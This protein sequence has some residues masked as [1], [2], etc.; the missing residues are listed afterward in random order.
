MPVSIL[1]PVSARR[2][3]HQPEGLRLKLDK[4]W[5]RVQQGKWY[6]LL[7]ELHIYSN[8][9]LRHFYALKFNKEAIMHKI[10]QMFCDEWISCKIVLNF[11][12]ILKWKNKSSERGANTSK[13][14][15]VISPAESVS[16]LETDTGSLSKLYH[17]YAN[18]VFTY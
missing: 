8:K 18:P 6:V 10:C 12:L 11:Y 3:Q 4:A 2:H 9:Y 14:K 7:F 13:Y 1:Q 16:A 17:I 5:Y 15:S